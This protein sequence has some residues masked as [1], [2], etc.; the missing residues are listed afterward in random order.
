MVDPSDRILLVKLR[1][2]N[3]WSG[4][5]LPGG[6][7]EAGEDP[8]AALAREI[9]EETGATSQ[10]FIGPVVARR[11]HIKPGMVKGFDGQ[12]ET[13][14][15]VPC[16]SFEIAPQLDP[17]Q[18]RAEGVVDVGWWTAADVAGTDERVVPDTLAELLAQVL[19]F[20]A[21]DEPVMI[22]LIESSAD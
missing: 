13:L 2:A 4:W 6:G 11:R 21:P 17:E 16:R 10:A 12:E 20:G 8:R 18:L 9:A 14:Y 19:E 15:L 22:K 7:I 3:D 1:L 5:V